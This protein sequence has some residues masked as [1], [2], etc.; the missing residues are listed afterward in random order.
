MTQRGQ[1]LLR[2][3]EKKD[4]P[5]V[6]DHTEDIPHHEMNLTYNKGDVNICTA[7]AGGFEM[8]ITES[9]ACSLMS[10]VTDWTFMNE[11]VVDGKSGFRIPVKD[12]ARP[13]KAHFALSRSR[14]WGNISVDKLSEKMYWCYLNQE[15]TRAMGKWARYNAATKY[16]WKDVAYIV[17]EEVLNEG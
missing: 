6:L 13:P 4:L 1:M 9:A 17:K 10:L 16:K 15:L 11:N 3:I 12:F 7:K 2:Y 14:I 8:G 5:I